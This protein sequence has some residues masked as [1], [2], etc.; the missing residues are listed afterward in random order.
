MNRSIHD[1]LESITADERLKASTK[2]FLRAARREKRRRAPRLAL[3]LASLVVCLCGLG[4][5][6]YLHAPVSYISIDINPSIEL[7]LNRMHR[8]VS[9]R[10]WNEDGE[11][12]VQQVQVAGRTYTEAIDA[13]LES[14]AMQPYLTAQAELTFTVAADDRQTEELLLSGIGECAGC[15]KYCGQRGSAAP[16]LVEEAHREGLSFGKYKAYVALRE[17]GAAV[18]LEECRNMSMADINRLL[19]ELGAGEGGRHRNG[20]EGQHRQERHGWQE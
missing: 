12:V 2:R 14:P 1:A 3:A 7:T 13:I 8:V 6:G 16:A 11:A 5:F 9:A 4:G 18:T 10:G 19:R 20:Q 17:Q 15:R